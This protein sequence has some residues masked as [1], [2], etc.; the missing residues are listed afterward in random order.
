MA[1]TKVRMKTV[2]IHFHDGFKMEIRVPEQAKYISIT[3][4]LGNIYWWENKPTLL[5]GSD[6]V[7][8]SEFDVFGT[9]WGY[10]HK[11]LSVASDRTPGADGEDQ[12]KLLRIIEE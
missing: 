12:E 5:A 7:S 6:Y 1:R 9:N 11:G 8:A 10:C 3:P 4:A 2:T